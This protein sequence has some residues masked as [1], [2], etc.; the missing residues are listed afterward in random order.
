MKNAILINLENENLRGNV[1][2]VGFYNYGIIYSLIKNSDDEISVDY[3]QGKGEGE[4]IEIDFYDCCI[5][6]FALSHIW[7]KYNRNKI[8]LDLVKHIKPE[9]II[10]IWDLNK[11]YAK[12]FSN[13]LKVILPGG[14]IKTINLSELNIAK[15]TSIKTTKKIVE[16]YFEIT[17][18]ICSD[19]IYCIKG[20]KK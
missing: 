13:N 7:L 20:K 12:I 10:Y 16:K 18:C 9:G 15:D 11:P 1:L 2:D 17:E 8:L 19:N 14:Q 5:V 3:L 4:G 6:F